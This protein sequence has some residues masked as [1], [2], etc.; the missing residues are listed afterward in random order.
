MGPISR[1]QDG[2]IFY[3]VHLWCHMRIKMQ[4]LKNVSCSFAF[5]SFSLRERKCRILWFRY[6]FSLC[7]YS[8]NTF[9][10]QF[11]V[12]PPVI[13]FNMPWFSFI[14]FLVSAWICD[15]KDRLSVHINPKLHFFC[16]L[17]S[18][19]NF[20]NWI[21]CHSS[22]LN[23]C[24]SLSPTTKFSSH[25]LTGASLGDIHCHGEVCLLCGYVITETY[26]SH[27]LILWAH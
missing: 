20:L 1:Y 14:I 2:D 7:Y 19:T 16:P 26:A 3:D 18:Q 8:D 27:D 6:T 22:N 11:I 13:A 17:F 9:C 12:F 23:L 15:S 4:D 10:I 21:F 5:S 25:N 24:T